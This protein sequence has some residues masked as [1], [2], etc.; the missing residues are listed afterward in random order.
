[1]KG[2]YCIMIRGSRKDAK[3]ILKGNRK[4]AIL[5]LILVSSIPGIA[6]GMVQSVFGPGYLGSVVG[7]LVSFLSLILMSGY[8]WALLDLVDGQRLIVES[9]FQG[10]Q[11][12]QWIKILLITIS[13]F[14]LVFLWSILLIVPGIMKHYSYSQ[15]L[16]LLKDHSEIALNDALKESKEMMHGYKLKLFLLDFSFLIW[17]IFPILLLV[18]MVRSLLV[19][20]N[21]ITQFSPRVYLELLI[22]NILPLFFVFGLFFL[23][24]IFILPYRF[25]ALQVFYRK[26]TGDLNESENSFKKSVS[27]G[28]ENVEV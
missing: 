14:L 12:R 15:S 11:K 1:M 13:K 19:R 24:S 16:N 3:R 25:T 2:T 5:C 10:L 18:N 26:L 8:K 21:A 20:F 23:L 17:Y 28:F 7:I 6:S 9:I 27:E 4:T 22:E